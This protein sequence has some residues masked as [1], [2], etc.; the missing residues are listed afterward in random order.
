MELRRVPISEV[1]PWDKNPRV[2]VEADCE[3]LKRQIKRLGVYKP[4]VV[5][6]D[7][8]KK[9]KRK[10]VVLGGNMRLLALRE[11][12]VK[13]VEVSVVEAKTEKERIEYSLSDNDRAGYYEEEGLAGIV[14]SHRGESDLG[15]FRVDL[16]SPI[17]LEKIVAGI[18]PESRRDEREM[19][20]LETENECPKRGYKW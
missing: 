9:G 14:Y 10:L 16:A 19:G 17:G 4:L 7:G 3:G 2:R 11:L 15:E 6:E 8:G 20:D 13:E 1:V 5:C 18:G 12:G